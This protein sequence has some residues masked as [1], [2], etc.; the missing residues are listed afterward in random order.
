MALKAVVQ[1]RTTSQ[2]VK[3]NKKDDILTTIGGVTL[4]N[5]INEITSIEQIADV[6][7]IDVSTGS[8]LVYNSANHKYEIKKLSLN[9]F[10]G[11]VS[12]D[13]GTF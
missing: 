4:K 6:D 5:Q 2:S 7:E 13:G 9:D 11:D 3:L 12:L 8:T 1:P 10:A